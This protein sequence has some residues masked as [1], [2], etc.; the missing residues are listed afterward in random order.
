MN[1]LLTGLSAFLGAGLAMVGYVSYLNYKKAQALLKFYSELKKSIE[2]EI[3]FVEIAENLSRDME[4][5]DD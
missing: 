4:R 2:D 5:Y 3:T 1:Y